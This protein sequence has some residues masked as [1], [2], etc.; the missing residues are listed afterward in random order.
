MSNI[1]LNSAGGVIA[2]LEDS[3]PTIKRYALQKLDDIVDEFWTEISDVVDKIEVLYEDENFADRKLA[4]LITSKVFYHLGV[5]EDAMNFALGAGDKFDV[6]VKSEYVDTILSQCLDAYVKLRLRMVDGREENVLIDNRLESI[7]NRMF[8]QCFDEQK[9]KLAVGMALE[10]RRVDFFEDA[11][12]QSD[13]IHSMLV[14]CMKI[15]LSLIDNRDFRNNVLGILV[16]IFLEQE[17][18]DHVLICQCYVFLDDFL[19]VSG[20]LEGLMRGGEDEV[21]IAYQIAFDLYENASQSFLTRVIRALTP[22]LPNPNMKTPAKP[23]VEA[24]TGENEPSPMELEGASDPTPEIAPSPVTPREELPVE[25]NSRLSH[26]YSILDGSATISLHQEFLIRNNHTDVQILKNIKDFVRHSI[27]HNATIATNGFMCYGTTQDVFLRNN[28]EW[29]GKAQNWAK[30]TATGSLGLIHWGHEKEALKV[31]STYLPKDSSGGGG[32]AYAEGG[33]LYALGLIHA[34]HGHDIIDY[35]Q[36]QLTEAGSEVIQH[37]GCLGLGLAA[38]GTASEDIFQ[39]LLQHLHKSDAVIGEAAGV[40]MG[41]VMMGTANENAL[42]EMI[43]YAQE[44]PHEK[45]LRGL[46]LGIS[47]VMYGTLDDADVLIETLCTDK[48][49]LLRRSGIYTIA[50]AYA[51]TGNNKAIRKLLHVAVSDV[52]DDVRRAAVMCL[53]FLLFQTPEQCPNAVSLLSESYNPHVRCGAALALGIACAGTGNKDALALLDTLTDDQ[54]NFVRQNAH[55]ASAMILMQQTEASN[56]KLAKFRDNYVK[57]VSDK[58]EDNVTKFGAIMAQGI[59]DAGGRN[60]TISLKSRSGHTNPRAVV[61]LLVFT[62]FWFWFPLAHFISLAFIPTSLIAIN[63]DL[64]LPKMQ[65]KSN[66]NPSLFAYPPPVKKEQEKVKSKVTT[67]ILSISAKGKRGKKGEQGKGEEK[68]AE[69]KET[70]EGKDEGDTRDEVK[71]KPETDAGE[72]EVDTPKPEATSEILSNPARILPK[73]LQHISIEEG[74]RYEPT[75]SVNEGGIILLRN[76]DP[77]SEEELVEK[78]RVILPGEE[79]EVEEPEA[80]EAFDW[81]DE[82]LD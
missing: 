71:S 61:G 68:E 13:D 67:A 20:I 33:S 41:L 10:T 28:L 62:H 46:A 22:N 56:S 25:L 58:H 72:M 36:K 51:G 30:F 17:K 45:I 21:L 44:T 15:V 82:F 77:G 49:P 18:L 60:V 34:N 54:S 70:V 74:C 16:R 14:Y 78:L 29:L 35:L 65:I 76:L 69:S 53:G 79:D 38:M 5:Y 31:M 9:F 23:L 8:K 27:T 63:Q 6:S 81:N 12:K 43:E 50:M 48:D 3:N 37:G 59:L 32:S 52:D 26:F 80:P 66:A 64:N 40:A 19:S 39:L 73:Q 55:I 47:L 4:A 2:L 42:K 1:C 7:V 24:A 57:V 75:K 11:I